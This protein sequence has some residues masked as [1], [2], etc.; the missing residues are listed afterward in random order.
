MGFFSFKTADT[1]ESIPADAA[2]HPRSGKVVY[3]LQPNGEK[4]ICCDGYD[5]FGVFGGQNIFSWLSQHNLGIDNFDIG[6]LIS[7]DSSGRLLNDK[8]YV[9]AMHFNKNAQNIIN[10]KRVD[11]GLEKLTFVSVSDYAADFTVQVDVDGDMVNRTMS[12]NLMGELNLGDK[13]TISEMVN[14]KCPIKLS[15]NESAVYEELDKS[16]DCEYQGYFY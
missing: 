7:C 11:D 5:G 15:Y 4:P 6:N 1:K 14:I 12:L 13:I 16:E 2:G 3:L 8:V 9:C 10:K